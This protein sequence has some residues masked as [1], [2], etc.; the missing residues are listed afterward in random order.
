MKYALFLGCLISAR[1]PSYELYARRVLPYFGVE[2]VDIPGT[3]CCAPFS[4]QSLDYVGWLSIAARNLAIAEEMGLPVL[5]FCNDCYESLLMTNVILRD[6]LELQSKVNEVL[7]EVDKEYKGKTQVKHLLE[8]LHQDV[9]VKKIK[10]ATKRPLKKLR[11]ATQIGCHAVRPKMIHPTLTVGLET[12][13][14][15]VKATGA[16]TVDYDKK[17]VCCG[18]PLRGV[19][20]EVSRQLS[21]Q[22]LQAIK[23]AGANCIVTVCPFCFIQFDLGQL[24]IKKTFGEKYDLP[25]LHVVELLALATGLEIE[26]WKMQD[27]RIPLDSIYKKIKR[28]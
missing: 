19:N 12:L 22:K 6:D 8:V 27:H 16:R 18:G 26:N 14:E 4:I 3:T 25:V 21:R 7:F 17:E 20:D 9:G 5:A 2:L 11:V 10:D 28:S 15:L 13:D 1:E 23:E 24:E